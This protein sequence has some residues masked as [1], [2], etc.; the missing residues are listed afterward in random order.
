MTDCGLD[1][2]L[3]SEGKRPTTALN[4]GAFA[5]AVE[6]HSK[7]AHNAAKNE[8]KW[9]FGYAKHVVRQVQLAA[10]SPQAAIGIATDGLNYL[11][12]SMQFLR[13]D[14]ETTLAEAM[15]TITSGS[16]DTFTIKGTGE[17]TIDCLEVPYGGR[18]LCREEVRSQSEEW[19]RRGV[20][21]LDT[22]A[23]LC[24]VSETPS[25]LDL[26]GFT[27]VLFGA[28]SAMGPFPILMSL[29][30]H[31][32]ALDLDRPQIWKRLISTARA[33]PGKLTIPL[34][35]AAPNGASDD[36]ISNLAGCNLL[37]QTPEVRN[38][39][40]KL[41]PDERLVLGGYCYADGPLFV[42]VSMAMDA[43]IADLIKQRKVKPALAYLCTPTDAHVCTSSSRDAAATNLKKQPWWQP[44]LAM[45]LGPAKMPM[46][47][48]RVVGEPGALP[49]VDAIVKEQGPNY[50][51][52]K[53]IQHWRSVLARKEGCTVSTNIAPSTATASVVSNKS[54]ALAY[55][56]MHFFRPMEVFQ[57]ETSNAVMAA[58]LV[59]DLQ[60]P[61]SVANPAIPLANPM[62]LFAATAFHG[63]AWR[64]GYKFGTIGP[65][66]VI[67]YLTKA[68]IVKAYLVLYSALQFIGWSCALY[69]FCNHKFDATNSLITPLTYLMLPE[70]AHAAIGMVPSNP[71]M[72]AMQVG[73]RINLVQVTNCVAVAEKSTLISSWEA[74]N[75]TLLMWAAWCITEVIRYLYYTLNTAG[76]QVAPLTWL[77]Y[78]TFLVLYPAGVTGELG[79]IYFGLPALRKLLGDGSS[80]TFGGNCG[81]LAWG[82]THAGIW[83]VL[84]VYILCFPMLFGTMQGQRR[85]VLGGGSRKPGAQKKDK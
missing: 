24:R 11:H 64:T 85:K 74:T 10:N 20:I 23:A 19:V 79:L 41:V 81:R 60:N 13:G 76:I 77:R 29:G 21:E 62:Q 53:R 6:K 22:G 7:E 25:W 12:N 17:S 26:S 73:S 82:T 72:T 43:I 34:K 40:L 57:Q 32:I 2:P 54:F 3:D 68:Y 55:K 15:K 49:V 78:S 36:E 51:L 58:L 37:T 83:P 69:N 65:P 66:S 31:V 38:W 4:Q 14:Q 71:V 35:K 61:S 18:T 63:G 59:N 27:F 5:A 1:F 80:C 8:K 52:A 70:V 47:K 9:R 42:R 67:A 33:S 39:L 75:F 16:F 44:L 56:G 28:G 30:A 50:C 45:M 46:S 84:L 48:N